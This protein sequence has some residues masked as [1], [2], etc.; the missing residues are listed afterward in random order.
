[1]ERR[2]REYEVLLQE[3]SRIE[4]ALRVMSIGDFAV[5]ELSR[6]KQT[7]LARIAVHE[8]AL[9]HDNDNDDVQ[10]TSPSSLELLFV[11][12]SSAAAATTP[13]HVSSR[14]V[15][16][17]AKDG[18][19]ATAIVH[20]IFARNGS[21]DACARTLRVLEQA[22]KR[23]EDEEQGL[24]NKTLDGNTDPSRTKC[25]HCLAFVK[26]GHYGNGPRACAL[27]VLA[28]HA[29]LLPQPP[30]RIRKHDND[31]KEELPL[32]PRAPKRKA[33]DAA[34]TSLLRALSDFREACAKAVEAM[35]LDVHDVCPELPPAWDDVQFSRLFSQPSLQ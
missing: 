8:I 26:R 2:K 13:E 21:G 24:K 7:H 17:A 25:P 33:M 1:M 32:R 20:D 19:R 29:L 10:D 12:G 4:A 35:G 16:L 18:E 22:V 30:A 14:L 31:N 9:A 11:A 23:L 5:A 34:T 6:A 3:V 27:R 28:E 15:S